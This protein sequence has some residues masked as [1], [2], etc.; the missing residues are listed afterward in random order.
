MGGAGRLL[1]PGLSGEPAGIGCAG[2]ELVPDPSVVASG[3]DP[4]SVAATIVAER[5]VGKR[6]AAEQALPVRAVASVT[7]VERRVI[8]TTSDTPSGK[9]A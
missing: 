2:V 9:D 7:R 8:K 6:V 1:G 5:P 4:P 3:P